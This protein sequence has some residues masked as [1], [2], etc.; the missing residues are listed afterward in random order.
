MHGVDAGGAEAGVVVLGPVQRTRPTSL[1]FHVPVECERV[2][3]QPKG[4]GPRPNDRSAEHLRKI[5]VLVLDGIALKRSWSCTTCIGGGC[6]L[7]PIL[8][9][10]GETPGSRGV[11]E[12]CPP[13]PSSPLT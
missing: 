3:R 9:T 7:C 5:V 11:A 2:R 10:I 1:S 6:P 4:A 12:A 8:G 13:L